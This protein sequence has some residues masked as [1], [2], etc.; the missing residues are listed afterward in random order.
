MIINPERPPCEIPRSRQERR[1][2]WHRLRRELL[3]SDLDPRL[4]EEEDDA[5]LEAL[6]LAQIALSTLDTLARKDPLD[7]ARSDLTNQVRAARLAFSVVATEATEEQGR[8]RLLKA[9]IE[10]VKRADRERLR[11]HWTGSELTA[12]RRDTFLLFVAASVGTT[13]VDPSV[14]DRAI[15]AALE[16]THGDGDDR[17]TAINDLAKK[18][19]C[20]STNYESFRTRYSRLKL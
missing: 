14:I 8:L 7:S 5:V 18:L 9:A 4:Y 15:H 16:K 20:G 10:H 2:L 12:R 17:W 3:T 1:A 6:S 13:N 11:K 19:G